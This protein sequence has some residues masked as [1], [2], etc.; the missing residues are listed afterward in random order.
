M[1]KYSK[2]RLRNGKITFMKNFSC[3]KKN[4]HFYVSNCKCYNT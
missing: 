3:R 4:M 1:E 2:R